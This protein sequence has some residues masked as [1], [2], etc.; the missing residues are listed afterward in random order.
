MMSSFISRQRVLI[1]V[2]S[3]S[4]ATLVFELVGAHWSN[5]LSLFS[6][7]SHILVDVLALLLSLLALRL[8][9]RPVS[10]KRTYGW[11]RAEVLAS[12][13]NGVLLLLIAISIFYQGVQRFFIPQPIHPGVTLVFGLIGLVA[14]VIAVWLLKR[15]NHKAHNLNIKSAFW[16]VL[17]DTVSSLGVVFS[18]VVIYW[19]GWTP[20][21]SLV[22]VLIGI[23]IIRG[24]VDL[25][26]ESVG[27][28]LEATPKDI[29]LEGLKRDIQKISGIKKIHDVHVWTVTSGRY[30]M[31]GHVLTTAKTLQQTDAL[32]LKIDLVLKKTYHVDH[33]TIQFE[34]ETCYGEQCPL[35]KHV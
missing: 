28:L 5:S 7:A 8:S 31:S 34:S 30:A 23:F 12:L 29:D 10:P 4:V 2:F 15:E 9:L 35:P 14:N 20:I 26:N 11:L 21:D 3:L 17:S 16:H 18:A 27:I 6:D 13:A 25:I 19:T 22:S 32:Y 1:S 33:S 24:A